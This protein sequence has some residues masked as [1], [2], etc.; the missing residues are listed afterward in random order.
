LLSQYAH[1]ARSH[2]HNF[3]S[4]LVAKRFEEARPKLEQR[5]SEM[6]TSFVAASTKA[7]TTIAASA[8]VV[9]SKAGETIANA[10]THAGSVGK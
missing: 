5:A 2:V 6:R 10:S 7:G 3:S 8:V 4:N 9:G 1:R